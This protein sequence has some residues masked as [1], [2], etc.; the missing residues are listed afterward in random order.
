VRIGLVSNEAYIARFLPYAGYDY[1]MKLFAELLAQQKQAAAE[2][3]TQLEQT[4]F[5]WLLEQ[6]GVED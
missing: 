6:E 2:Q 5:E 4:P 3:V 1:F